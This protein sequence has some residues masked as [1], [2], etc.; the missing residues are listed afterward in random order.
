MNMSERFDYEGYHKIPSFCYID[1]HKNDNF[2]VIIATE[3]DYDEEGAGT[4]VT[5][6][7]EHIATEVCKQYEIPQ[8]KLAW[9]EHY[10]RSKFELNDEHEET[11][12]LVSF[13]RQKT[14]T[15][16]YWDYPRGEMVFTSPKWQHLTEEQKD[17]LV[18]GDL[19]VFKELKSLQW[20][21]DN[22]PEKI[23]KATAETMYKQRVDRWAQIASFN[24]HKKLHEV[25]QHDTPCHIC[26]S[27]NTV[28]GG[29]EINEKG[30]KVC[31]VACHDCE[32]V[33]GD[34]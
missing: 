7:A 4:S 2:T 30:V 9:I 32:M 24:G 31:Y 27:E 22:P 14:P 12:D 6:R 33:I 8:E 10:D 23:N 19:G 16:D 11:W 18:A 26:G 29:S 25:F 5:N 3:P 28:E 15:R 34:C 1:I 21:G 13:S 17:R 20:Q